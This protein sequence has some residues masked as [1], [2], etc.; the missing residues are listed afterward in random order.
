MPVAGPSRPRPFPVFD[1]SD[2]E[3]D[4]DGIEDVTP[5]QP[6]ALTAKAATEAS[7][8]KAT[9]DDLFANSDG[10]KDV[11]DDVDKEYEK[12]FGQSDRQW[13][14]PFLLLLCY[15]RS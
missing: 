12:V 10:A 13:N 5:T 2:D 6:E 8:V 15:R 1:L 14:T 4:F 3:D 11:E 7:E 9:L